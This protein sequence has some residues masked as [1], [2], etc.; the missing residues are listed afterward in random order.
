M[1]AKN[2]FKICKKEFFLEDHSIF[3]ACIKNNNITPIKLPK[4]L[5]EKNKKMYLDFSQYHVDM[6]ISL[7]KKLE[8]VSDRKIFLFG[9]HIFSQFLIQSGLNTNKITSILDNDPNKQGKVCM[10][11]L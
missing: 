2:N 1:L 10:A 5:Y 9:A 8:F 11:H 3:Y 7:N 6:V 4:N